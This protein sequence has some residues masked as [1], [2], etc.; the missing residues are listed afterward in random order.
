MNPD[1]ND[2]DE[3][4]ENIRAPDPVIRETLLGTDNNYDYNINHINSNNVNNN[5]Y[6]SIYDFEEDDCV[7]FEDILKQSIEEYE[8]DQLKRHIQNELL[9]KER[10]EKKLI[11]T[12]IS[13]KINRVKGLDTTNKEVYETVLSIIEMYELDHIINFVAQ[14][15]QHEKM[16]KI[17]N[18]I[19]LT[20]DEMQFLRNLIIV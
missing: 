13:Q 7:F 16:F 12:S 18:S 17:L 1:D 3:Q 15:N 2:D 6:D 14:Q 19:R 20:L 11:C 10:L 4:N 9:E 5:Y 8:K